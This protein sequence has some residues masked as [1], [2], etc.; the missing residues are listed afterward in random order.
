[1][2]YVWYFLPRHCSRRSPY[3]ERGLKYR[4]VHPLVEQ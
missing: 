1:M 3:G 4:T 2:K